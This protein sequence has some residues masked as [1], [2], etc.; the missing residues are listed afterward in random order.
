LQRHADFEVKVSEFSIR[1]E[2]VE[3]DR[4]LKSEHIIIPLRMIKC[5]KYLVTQNF[6]K[7]Q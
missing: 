5:V 7:K 4:S 6:Q 3:R 1:L 2:H